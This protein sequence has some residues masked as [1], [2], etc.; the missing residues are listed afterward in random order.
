MALKIYTY[1]NCGTCRKAVRWLDDKGISYR[2]FP[3]REVPPSRAELKKMLKAMN[4]DIKKLFNTSG[5]DYRKLNM[6]ELLPELSEKDALELLTT[7]GNLVKR[8]FVLGDGA[9]TAGFKEETWEELF[10]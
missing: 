2:E 9:A 1:K 3:I 5:M 10:G 6:K 8:P 7:N 4:G